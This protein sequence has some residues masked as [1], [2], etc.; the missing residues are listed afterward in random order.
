M[1]AAGQVLHFNELQLKLWEAHLAV[2]YGEQWW[3]RESLQWSS[4]RALEQRSWVLEWLH[5]K[6]VVSR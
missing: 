6:P 3:V 1:S 2:A 4:A 5:N